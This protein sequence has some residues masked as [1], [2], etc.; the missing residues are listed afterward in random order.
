[1]EIRKVTTKKRMLELLEPGLCSLNRH[2]QLTK[3]KKDIPSP[4]QGSQA[5]HHL[6]SKLFSIVEEE[7]EDLR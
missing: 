3:S 4:R 1:M 7:T 2:F 5:G 6:N